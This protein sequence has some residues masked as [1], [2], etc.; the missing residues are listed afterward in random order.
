M[1]APLWFVVAGLSGFVLYMAATIKFA[2]YL[3]SVAMVLL[4]AIVV[5]LLG[6]LGVWGVSLLVE[7]F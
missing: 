2:D 5:A 1:L 3:D 6:C 7:G 4:T